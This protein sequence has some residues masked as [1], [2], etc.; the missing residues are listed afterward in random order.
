MNAP[1]HA[2]PHAE[3]FFF[4][5]EPGTRFCMYH[6]PS[7]HLAPRGAILY[8]HPFAEELN[9]SR[10]MA[11]QQAR[12]FASLG[13][14]VLQIDL[15]GCGDSCGDFSAGRWEQWQRDLEDMYAFHLQIPVGVTELQFR[16]TP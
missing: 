11:A 14:A 12:A 8:V 5:V 1:F 2:G 16:M 7:T 10:R 9:L 15:F 13:F 6:P 3:P 4:D